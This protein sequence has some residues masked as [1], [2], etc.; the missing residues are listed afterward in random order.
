[1]ISMLWSIYFILIEMLQKNFL[2]V[3][4]IFVPII[5]IFVLLFYLIFYSCL[6]FEIEVKAKMWIT[7]LLPHF[8]YRYA[9]SIILEAN[10]NKISMSILRKCMMNIHVNISR[11]V[12]SQYFFKIFKEMTEDKFSRRPVYI[13]KSYS[14]PSSL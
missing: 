2:H 9:P 8:L 10:F 6:Y 3:I 7:Y 1:M 5:L 12:N 11:L 14:P 13:S 4:H